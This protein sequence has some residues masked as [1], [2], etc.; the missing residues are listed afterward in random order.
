MRKSKAEVTDFK[1][2]FE[3]WYRENKHRHE[4]A[5]HIR[6]M[7]ISA[8]NAGLRDAAQDSIDTL[9]QYGTVTAGLSARSMT[10][11]EMYD[12]AAKNLMVYFTKVLPE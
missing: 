11:T 1:E 12:T 7:L 10:P 4:G 2:M 6:Y 3:Q 5:C 9:L 8:Y